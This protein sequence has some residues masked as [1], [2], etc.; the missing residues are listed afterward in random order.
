MLGLLNYAKN[1]ASAIEKRLLEY[2]SQNFFEDTF[3]NIIHVKHRRVLNVNKLRT[4]VFCKQFP[5]L[6]KIG[7]V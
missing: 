5:S 6:V 2:R 1:D 3:R 4:E 7:K